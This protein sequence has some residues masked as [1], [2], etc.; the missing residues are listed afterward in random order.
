MKR[1]RDQNNSMQSTIMSLTQK[2]SD[3]MTA[4]MKV[5]DSSRVDALRML[6]AALL[7]LQKS[8]DEVTE[9]L[10]MKVLQKQAKMRRESISQFREAGRI[11][12]AEREEK[13]LD[14]IEEYLPKMLSDE[15]ITEIVSRVITETGAASMGDFKVVMPKTMKEVSGRADGTAVQRIVRQLLT[16]ADGGNA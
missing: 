14:I 6:R 2:I 4:A 7:E 10:E 12:L 1:S 9:D 3:D 8:G 11:D 13:E 5:R 16:E 15:D